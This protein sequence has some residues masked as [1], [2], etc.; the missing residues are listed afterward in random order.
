MGLFGIAEVMENIEMETEATEILKTKLK[1]LLP[2]LQDWR[3][4]LGAIL[5]G[6]II[7]FF[8]G[9]LPGGGAIMGSFTYY[10]IEKRLSKHPERF[11]KGAIEGVAGPESA[12]NS[13]SSSNFIPLMTLGL[14]CNVVM[15]LLLGALMIHGI[16]PGPMLIQERP[17]LFWGLVASM[18][19]G[20][21]MLLLLNLPL[22]G[23]W[24]RVLSIPYRL[25]FVLILLFCLTGVYSLNNNIWEIIIMITF[26]VVGY[27]MRKFKYEAAPFVF[28]LVLGPMMENSLR[29]SL[30][31]SEGS[32]AIFFTRPIS[33]IQMIIGIILFTLPALPWFKRKQFVEQF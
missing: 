32:F 31:M 30:L 11:G 6:T 20:N 1:G 17:D 33:C 13:A 27:L 26:G 4:S 12:N 22:I 25:L 10:A 8:L 5:R 21:T 15:A 23:L 19:I 9:L 16:R 28:A 24:V 14:P 3:D 29:Q 7:G 2:S 18:Y